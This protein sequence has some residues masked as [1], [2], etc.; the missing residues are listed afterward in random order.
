MYIVGLA[1]TN[2]YILL[3]RYDPMNLYVTISDSECQLLETADVRLICMTAPREESISSKVLVVVKNKGAAI[4]VNA[5][6]YL[7]LKVE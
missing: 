6:Y 4:E 5:L 7:L 2:H 1:N 3:F